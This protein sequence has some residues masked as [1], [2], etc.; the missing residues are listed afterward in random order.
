MSGSGIN[1][2]YFLSRF[3][4]VILTATIIGAAT[5]SVGTAMGGPGAILSGSQGSY[6][7]LTII[8]LSLFISLALF[9]NFSAMGFPPMVDTILYSFFGLM[10]VL[11][12]LGFLKGE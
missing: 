2:Q 10:I 11:S 1:W 3:G 6:H 9:P 8:S 5:V 12:I 7:V 4:W